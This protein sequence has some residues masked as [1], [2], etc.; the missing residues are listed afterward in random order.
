MQWLCATN[1]SGLCSALHHDAQ[2]AEH[3][4]QEAAPGINNRATGHKKGM[5]VIQPIDWRDLHTGTCQKNATAP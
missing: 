1:P 2:I 4:P 3:I 5:G